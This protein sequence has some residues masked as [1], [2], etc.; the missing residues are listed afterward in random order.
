MVTTV[1]PL[2]Q[3]DANRSGAGFAYLSTVFGTWR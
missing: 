1:A 2:K 3:Q